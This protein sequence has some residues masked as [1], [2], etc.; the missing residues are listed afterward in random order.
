MKNDNPIIEYYNKIKSGEIL[1]SKKVKTVYKQLVKDI[2]S[3]KKWIY[4]PLK[5]NHAIYFVENFCKHSKGIHANKPVILELWEKAFVAAIYGIVDKKTGLRRFHEALLIVGKKNGKSLLASA[6]SLYMLIAD[7][8]GGAECYSVATKRDQAKIVFQEAENMVKKSPLLR[9]NVKIRVNK[10]IYEVANSI[11]RPLSSDSST[12]DGLN[13]HFADCDEIHA[14][15]TSE[16]YHIIA[17]GTSARREPLILLTSTAGFERE[18]LYDQKYDEAVKVLNGYTDENGYKDDRFFPVIYE[19]DSRSEWTNEKNWIKAN[20]NLRVSKEI[21]YLRR[22]VEN[23][24]ENPINLKNVLTKEFNIPETSSEVWLNFEDIDNKATFDIEK[25]KPRYGIAG[26]DLSKTTDLTAACV[27]FMVDGS[28][29]IYCE[30]MYFLPSELL[31]KRTK[32]DKIPYDVWL[33]KGLLRVSS[34][35][36]INY[37]DVVDWYAEIQTKYD[38]YLYQHRYDS[39]NSQAFIKEFDDYFGKISVPVIQ[40]KKTL[41]NPMRLLGADLTSKKVNYN[42]NP[43]TKWCLTNVRADVDKN[44][45]I[46]PAKTSNPNRRIDGFAAM[47]NAYVGLIEEKSEYLRLIKR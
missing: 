10:L 46:Q 27:M 9:E 42:N 19:L 22:K 1:T 24:K 26:T 37:S 41:S 23:A 45:N 47:L 17:D 5:A 16:L 6:I 31:E 12:E 32:E 34:G 21:D 20:P 7:G 39:W 8:E 14:W 2:K 18:G 40:G 4:N 33:E 44:D 11:Y 29:T 25:L 28:E 36:N 38:V 35:N 13:I 30:H 15:K 3:A 43:I